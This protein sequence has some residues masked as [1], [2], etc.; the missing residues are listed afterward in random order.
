LYGNCRN[1][2]KTA[3]VPDADVCLAVDVH[4]VATLEV[5]QG[6][7]SSDLKR[8]G[9]VGGRKSWERADQV[10]LGACDAFQSREPATEEAAVE[11]AV[12]LAAH[13]RRQCCTLEPRSHGR[14][15]A[16][17]VVFPFGSMEAAIARLY[18]PAL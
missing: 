17:L 12:E 3:F 9:H 5:R 6:A 13:E 15:L 18:R 11:V 7:R 1:L 4:D 10:L 14:V 8:I 2:T 16:A